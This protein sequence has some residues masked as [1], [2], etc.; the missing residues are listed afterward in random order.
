LSERI[1]LSQFGWQG[2]PLIIMFCWPP[3]HLEPE[4]RHWTMLRS[5]HDNSSED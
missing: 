2:I 3:T 4:G 5:Y 1:A